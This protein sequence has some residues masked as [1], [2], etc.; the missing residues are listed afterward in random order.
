MIDLNAIPSPCYVMEEKLLRNNLALIKRVKEEAGV[1][2]ILAFKAFALWKS[3]PI[4]REYIPYSTA[5]SKFEAQ[6]AFEEMGSPAHTYS[7]AYTEA[8]F[9]AILKYSSHITFNSLSQFDRFY[10]LVKADGRGI[11]CGLRINPEFSDV[12]T[13]LYNPCAPGSR[14]GIVRDLLGET[15][16]EGVEGL[17]FHTLCESSSY[18]L[19]RTLQEVD[20][21]F[22]TLLSQVKWLNMGGGH[23]MTRKDYD[24][25]HLVSV[26]RAFKT[27]YPN[28]EIIMEPG[29]AFAWQTG[30]LLTTVVDIVENKG[31]K[32]AIIDASF[33]CHMPDCLEMPYKP[34]IRNATDA[35]EGKPT[36][37]I[38]GN[39][40]LSGDYMGDWSFDK[41]LE[42]GDK[43]IFEDMIHYT[44]VKT[45]MFNGIPHPSLAL[46]SK[47]DELVLYRSFGYEDYKNR[48][49]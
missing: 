28:L 46:W 33:T 40:C 9:P 5:S 29:S 48:M 36:Y 18:D 35:V 11:S 27:K 24:T 2:I 16:P 7:P 42:V 39:S 23:L 19:E 47:E 13:D 4:V 21:K 44:I 15:L 14:M 22:G 31:I 30:F 43:V 38:G 32:T 49:S 12:E 10:P 25:A 3:F 6:L 17:H 26:L 1:N 8:D 20:K 34:A 45:S 37:R 41:P